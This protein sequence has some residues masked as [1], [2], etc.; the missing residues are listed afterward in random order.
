MAHSLNKAASTTRQKNI[1]YLIGSYP[2]L[3]TTFIDREIRQM[4]EWGVNLQVIS[5]R[6][7][8]GLLSAEQRELQSRVTY[9]LPVSWRVLAAAHLHFAVF[10]LPLYLGTLFFLLTRPHPSLKSRFMTL[11]HFVEGVYAAGIL[12]QRACDHIHAHFMDRAA[13]AALVVS[14]LLHIPY[15]V[16]AHA[17]DIYVDPVLVNEKLSLAKFVATCTRYNYDYLSRLGTGSF[18]HKMRCIYHGVDTCLCGE[19]HG[20]SLNSSSPDNSSP[21]S[22]LV[23]AVGQLKE[24][25]G[26]TYLIKACRIM[27][28]R[29]FDLQCQIVGDG[30]LRTTL[31][32]EINQLTL[33]NTVTLCGPLPAQQVFGKYR[34]AS[35]FTLPAVLA[36]NGDRDGIPNVILEAMAFE[37]PVISTN[38]SAIPEAVEDGVTGLIVPPADAVALADALACLLSD[39]G[40][41]QRLGKRGR[42]AVIEKF[43]LEH[44]LKQLYAEFN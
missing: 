23:L 15:S 7:P 17:N 32:A 13:T 41:R 28:D 14:R 6:Q 8:H 33:Q 29:G 18:S 16:T 43:S 36:S 9:L 1:T 11:L 20:S 38:H 2:L 5:I 42:Q 34:Q 10:S 37:L 24:K 25:K 12:R 35:I 26:F 22:S 3:T 44:N 31:Q 4:V 21:E 39:E 40:Y 19:D 27:K 30:A